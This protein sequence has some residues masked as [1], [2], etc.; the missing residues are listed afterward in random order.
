MTDSYRDRALCDHL[1]LDTLE[2]GL[3]VVNGDRRVAWCN[4]TLVRTLAVRQ[5]DVLG[6]DVLS[7]FSRYLAPILQ[8]EAAAVL[9]RQALE[10]GA[11]LPALLCRT[12]TP[13]G[14]QRWLSISGIPAHAEIGVGPKV[15]RIRDATGNVNAHYFRTALDRSPVVVF[16]QDRGLRYIW[17]YN[18]QLG[19][20][21]TSIIGM[22]DPEAFLSDEAAHLT[23]LKRRVLETGEIIRAEA[24]L[25][26]AGEPHVRDLT[27]KPL[28]D[29][30]GSIVGITGTAF[31][32]TERDR[33]EE[34]LRKRTYDLN[35]RMNE[36]RCL[37]TI[38]HLV[39]V[40]GITLDRLLQAVADTL[41]SGWQYPDDTAAR[42]TVEGREYRR[43]DPGETPWKQK[44]PIV[45]R[46]ACV[47]EVE[48]RY[49]RERPEADEGPFLREERMLLDAV[50]ER[51]G[52]VIERMRAEAALLNSEE[53][54][55]GIAQRSFDLIVT[56]YLA[57][58]LNYV[59]PAM[60][61]ILG[62]HPEEMAGTDWED[63]VLQS[64]L[65][66]WEEGRRKVL[67]GEQVEGLRVEV[68]RKDG[69]TAV[70]E[71]NESPI[72]ENG[73]IVG[74][75]AV[76]RDISERI[77]YERLREQAFD[78]TARNIAQFA[79]LADHVRHP[80]QVIMGIAD[81]LEDDETAEKLREQVRR[82]N[83][84]VSQLDREW[85]ESRKIREFLKRY[86]L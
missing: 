35:Q 71:L 68:R 9:I 31:D 14:S 73:M 75:Q 32:V 4:P 64:S 58:G 70:L 11:D 59:S 23:A 62:Y 50:A 77:L 20:T 21:D 41:P 63:Y 2:D 82:I 47:G 76:G 60:E 43:G 22:A 39:E 28:R 10:N 30:G 40:P 44:S 38:A 78:M 25:T 66:V 3:L 17:S 48:V 24:V 7:L 15:I 72:V 74:F 5:E 57:G 36:L 55:R 29:A 12:R 45:V 49:L 83:R 42:I 67:R 86:E 1:V 51:L 69:E 6:A 34:A 8:D 37:Y 53:K 27:L 16:A 46:G 52:R 33:A 80:L 61:R 85:M 81:L 19:P 54:F 13:D 26:V 79:V 65:L 18:Q 84:R 56:S